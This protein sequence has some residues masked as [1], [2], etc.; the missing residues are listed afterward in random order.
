MNLLTIQPHCAMIRA[1]ANRAEVFSKLAILES[2][3]LSHTQVWG[4]VAQFSDNKHVGFKLVTQ[5]QF[6]K[7]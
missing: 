5:L 4:D 1:G 6:F 3:S 7:N 2:V